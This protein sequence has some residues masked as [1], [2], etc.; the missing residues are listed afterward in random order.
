MNRVWL[1]VRRPPRATSSD[2][3]PSGTVTKYDLVPLRSTEPDVG[4]RVGRA[5]PA[6][7][8]TTTVARICWSTPWVAGSSTCRIALC[9]PAAARLGLRPSTVTGLFSGSAT[10]VGRRAERA[11]V[12]RPAAACARTAPAGPDGAGDRDVVRLRLLGRPPGRPHGRRR[13]C[14]G[15]GSSGSSSIAVSTGAL[16]VYSCAVAAPLLE[17]L[18]GV[19][20]V[21]QAGA[22]RVRRTPLMCVPRWRSARCAARP[23]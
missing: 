5:R 7:S 1:P 11:V 6:S 18:P 14:R 20:D 13:R 10:V 4:D 15:P 21:D 8:A 19:D 22:L 12:V 16:T 2:L 23:G 9:T 3:A 17:Q